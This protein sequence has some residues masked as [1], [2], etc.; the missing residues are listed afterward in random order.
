M[1]RVAIFVDAGYLFAQGSAALAGS[2]KA[3][4]EIVLDAS[5][6]I[7]ALRSLAS[8]KA[9]ECR[10]LRIYWY[11]GTVGGARHTTDQAQLANLDDVKLRLGFVNS[12][13]E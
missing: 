2:K 5:Q 13:G 8:A 9:P 6:I 3:R 10:L 7:A 4:D 11:D 1:D 12:A